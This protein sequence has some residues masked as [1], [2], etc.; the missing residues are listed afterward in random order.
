MRLIPA[1]V[2]YRPATDTKKECGTCEYFFGHSYCGMFNTKVKSD[3]VCD[4]WEHVTTSTTPTMRR[5]RSVRKEEAKPVCLH[6][7]VIGVQRTPNGQHVYRTSTR[8]GYYVGRTAP[9]KVRAKKG[10]TIHVHAN[11]FKQTESGDWSWMNPVVVG[12]S[13]GRDPYDKRKMLQYI[14]GNSADGIPV[15]ETQK[16]GP[17][18]TGGD[19]GGVVP[20]GPAGGLSGPT[21]SQVHSNKPLKII[22]IYYGQG[23][24]Q[25]LQIVKADKM[26]QL[27][28]TVA[29]EPH[30]VDTQ[31]DWETPDTIETAAHTYMTKALRGQSTVTKL[32]HRRKAFFKD[33]PSVVPVESFIAPMDFSYAKEHI[34]KG[35][36]VVVFKVEDKQ[37]WQDVLDGKYTG[38]SVGGSGKR[39]P[40]KGTDFPAWEWPPMLAPGMQF[41]KDEE[42][43]AAALAKGTGAVTTLGKPNKKTNE[44]GD[45]VD[46]GDPGW[47]PFRT[48]EPVVDPIY[49]KFAFNPENGEMDLWGVNALGNPHHD[50]ETKDRDV[51]GHIYKDGG[52]FWHHKRPKALTKKDREALRAEL[53]PILETWVKYYLGKTPKVTDDHE[54]P[55]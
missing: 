18:P 25:N 23:Q 22:S 7:S 53:L 39:R 50:E 8:D 20:N 55:K 14:G 19:T 2:H 38:V 15:F 44:V 12:R 30:E 4:E 34:K 24:G 13:T 11:H 46:R 10:Q 27:V 51:E 33:R 54:P 49:W 21:L 9:T 5:E 36:W 52:I 47:F 37:V 6:L 16:D 45:D 40:M 43:V 29:L 3:F 31:G 1:S 26:K 32:Q 42:R 41:F 28:Y 17:P 48:T 35:S